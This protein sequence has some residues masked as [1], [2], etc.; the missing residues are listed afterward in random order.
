MHGEGRL[1]EVPALLERAFLMTG[2]L[3]VPSLIFLMLRAGLLFDAWVGASLDEPVLRQLGVT[4]RFM[5]LGQGAYVFCLPAYYALLGV[6]HHRQLG[7][8][9]LAVAVA[10]AVLGWV[11]AGSLPDIASLGL[12]FG[13][14]MLILSLGITLPAATR[15]F[16]LRTSHVLL[17]SLVAPSL[18]VVP[19][20]LVVLLRPRL[21]SVAWDLA[22][23]AL[24][25]GLFSLPGLEFV[26]RRLGSSG[27][28]RDLGGAQPGPA[29]ISSDAP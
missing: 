26:R 16:G 21:G 1:S 28:L 18:A 5:L 14:L 9:M 7:W 4:A 24:G 25:F 6:G 19:G 11:V 22:L 10:N 12:V 27:G 29:E 17:K 3:A 23:D 2:L 8:A 13:V 20:A 15:R